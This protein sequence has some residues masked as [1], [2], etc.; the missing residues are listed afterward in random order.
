MTTLVYPHGRGRG[1][2]LRYALR[3][4]G[5]HTAEGE[6][7]VVVIGERPTW[8]DTDRVAFVPVVQG[9]DQF[10]NIWAAW[11]AA[12]T[13]LVDWWWMN[14]D[15]LVGAGLE[16]VLTHA[17]RGPLT[18]FC[19]AL[20][21]RNHVGPWRRRARAACDVLAGAG[22]VDAMSWEAHRPM[23]ATAEDVAAA[24]LFL[25]EHALAGPAVAE[26]TLIATLARRGGE[27][28]FDPKFNDPRGQLCGPVVSLGPAAWRGDAGRIVRGLYTTPSRW[29]R[30]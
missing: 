20:E 19:E 22:Y 8:L 16:H 9:R 4:L 13:H 14:D 6:V 25:A 5:A 12:A 11:E 7:D 1:D 30:H 26:R 24:A 10:V 29:E 2:L 3:T 28:L 15:F 18:A 21:R 23:Y 27:H 17:H